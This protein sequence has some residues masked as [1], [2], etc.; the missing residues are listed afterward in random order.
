MRISVTECSSVILHEPEN[1]FKKM[2]NDALKMPKQAKS[3][4]NDVFSILK[5]FILTRN[6][7]C[8]GHLVPSLLDIAFVNII[9]QGIRVFFNLR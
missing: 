5:Y 4:V 9:L 7:T 8:C 3:S 1:E 2:K 6:I